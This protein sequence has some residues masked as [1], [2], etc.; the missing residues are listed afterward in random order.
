MHYSTQHHQPCPRRQTRA[1]SCHSGFRT[2]PARTARQSSPGSARACT[3]PCLCSML[4]SAVNKRPNF[5][6]ATALLST[7]A[8]L[9]RVAMSSNQQLYASSCSP[10]MTVIHSHLLQQHH[11]GLEFF[12]LLSAQHAKDARQVTRCIQQQALG[13]LSVTA[14]TAR[15]LRMT[16]DLCVQLWSGTMAC[17]IRR[18]IKRTAGLLPDTGLLLTWTSRSG[19][20]SGPA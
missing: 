3:S 16:R 9:L 1:G 11:A 6:N 17:Q 4:S 20:R 5:S 12:A 15:F 10:F 19:Q 2:P 14:R 18:H 7:P 13:Q 8:D